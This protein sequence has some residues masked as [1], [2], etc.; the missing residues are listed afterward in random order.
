[1]YDL[2]V[3]HEWE[4]DETL[5]AGSA[6]FYVVGRMPYPA[7]V[8]DAIRAQLGLDGQGRLLDVGCGPGSLTLLLAPWFEWAVGVDAD[9]DMLAHARQAAQRRG[10]T[11][12]DWHHMRAEDLPGGLGTF[13]VVTFAQ[14]FHWVD[15]PRV[16]RAVHGMLESDGFWVHIAATTDRGV[17][18]EDPLPHPRPPHDEIVALIARYLGPIRRAGRGLLPSGTADG[19]DDVMWTAGYH[20]P[21]RVEVGGGAIVERTADEVVASVFSLSSSAPHLFGSRLATFEADLR[22]LL[23]QASPSG[24]FAERTREI[25]LSIWRP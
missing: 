5:Y 24:R 23:R 1:L 9:A 2:P 19:E 11:N 8:A 10:A 7:E 3:R 14:S 4:W 18:G 20:G 15:Q 6:P 17:P 25:M 13:R 12:V 16:A 21:Q 22:S